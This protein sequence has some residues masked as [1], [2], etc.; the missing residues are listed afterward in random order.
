MDEF[1]RGAGLTATEAARRAQIIEATIDTVAE[2]GYGRASF[3]R[4]VERA[5]L[6]STR[7]IS[8]HFGT[9]DDLMMATLG[10]V[11][12]AYDRFVTERTPVD[13]GRAAMLRAQIEAEAAFLTAHPRS[14][15][16][17]VEIGAGARTEDG[18]PPFEL[19]TRDLRVGRLERQLLQGQREGVF[20][21]FDA[22]VMAMAIRQALD[23]VVVRSARDP[24][25]DVGAYGRELAGLFDRATRA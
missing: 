25:L 19:V 7:M 5:G 16:A 20:G 13:A 4:I 11:I 23:G 8:Y 14:A 6:S 22:A 10:A 15:R 9:R 21:E 17:L 18:G 3:A 12:D 24:D 2:L 1:V